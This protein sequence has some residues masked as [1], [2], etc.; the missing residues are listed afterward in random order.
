MSYL[1]GYGV[2]DA[3]REK[4]VKWMLG[5]LIALLV[6]GLAG[7]F[8]FRN[9]SE[10]RQIQKF[11]DLLKRQDYKGAYALW[12]CTDASPCP[13][14]TFDKFMEDWGPK[15]PQ[16]NIAEAKLSTT[17]SCDAGIIQFVDFPDNHQVQ[18]WVERRDQFIGFAPWPVCNPRMKV[19]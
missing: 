14:Y 13:N 5:G 9:F 19:P 4:I 12:G 7:Y 2:K 11:V 8:Q 10:E 3:R 18:L 15:S 1:E 6:L 17:K 16:A